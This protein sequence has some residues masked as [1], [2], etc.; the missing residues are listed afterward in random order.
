MEVISVCNI[1]FIIKVSEAWNN[2]LIL[3]PSKVTAL[4]CGMHD[5]NFEYDKGQRGW[6]PSAFITPYWV[7]LMYA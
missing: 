2:I 4:S 6:T 1:N 5:Y 7:N 3:L